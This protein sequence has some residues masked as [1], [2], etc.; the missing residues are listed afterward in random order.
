MLTWVCKTRK[1]FSSSAVNPREC[2]EAQEESTLMARHGALPKRYE[3]YQ[4]KRPLSVSASFLCNVLLDRMSAKVSFS[5]SR[6][7][8]VCL[9]MKDPDLQISVR[10]NSKPRAEN[11]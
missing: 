6:L 5:S 3:L 2:P 1:A 7:A 9:T 11:T 4:C 8:E 10:S